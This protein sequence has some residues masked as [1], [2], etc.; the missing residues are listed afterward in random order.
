MH[1]RGRMKTMQKGM[2]Q[3]GMRKEQ[4]EGT[5]FEKPQVLEILWETQEFYGEHKS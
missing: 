1:T 4:Q 5:N 3:E 2:L